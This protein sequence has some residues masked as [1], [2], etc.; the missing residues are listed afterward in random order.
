MSPT[1][2]V[3]A[4][5]SARDREQ[6]QAKA[7]ADAEARVMAT[8]P[9]P[10]VLIALLPPPLAP[11]V[12]DQVV[13]DLAELRTKALAEPAAIAAGEIATHHARRPPVPEIDPN[14][15]L[16]MDTPVTTLDGD[17]LARK[18]VAQRLVELATAPP[19]AQP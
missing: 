6:A 15:E 19:L 16:L 4:A 11:D 5:P 18:G 14:V 13:Q 3:T 1:A 10:A 2:D 17:T 7:A 8:L 12:A 9:A